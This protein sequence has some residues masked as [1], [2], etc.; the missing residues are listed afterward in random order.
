ML[1]VREKL[2]GH[3][4][5]YDFDYYTSYFSCVNINAKNTYGGYT[6]WQTHMVK[7]KNGSVE[8]SQPESILCGR[9][10]EIVIEEPMGMSGFRIVGQ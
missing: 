4:I 5:Y 2:R 1:T 3:S 8:Y 10:G 7:F 6:G 9:E